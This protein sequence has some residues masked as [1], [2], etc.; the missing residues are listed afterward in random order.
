MENAAARTRSWSRV[1]YAWLIAV[2]ILDEDEKVELLGG[3]LVVREPQRAW[4]ATAI[5]LV[6][7]ELRRAFGEG[8]EI[9]RQLPVALGEES[10]PEPDIA[11]VRKN[12]GTSATLT[13]R[14]RC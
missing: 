10:E 11:V 5:R 3:Q 13:R 12:R 14:I 6:S 1:E 4:Y 2:G 9:D 7:A 8:W